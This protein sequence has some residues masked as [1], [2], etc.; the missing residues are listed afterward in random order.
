MYIQFI[1]TY[2][3]TLLS[4][5]IIYQDEALIAIH[6]PYGFFVHKSA[7]DA[8][9]DQ[10]VLNQLRDQIG[11]YVYP[12]HRLDRKTSGL[13]L[14]A[15]NKD[16]QRKMN[17]LFM[18]GE[19]SK[20]YHA[21]VRGHTPQSLTID[22]PLLHDD[23]RMQDAATVLE[24]LQKMEIPIANGNHPTSR[25]SLVKLMPK[26]GRM[27]QLRRHMAH[28]FHPILADRPHGCNKQNKLF[29]EKFQLHEMM[30]HARSLSFVKPGSDQ[31]L[32]IA[33]EYSNEFSRILNG[34]TFWVPNSDY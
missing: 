6:K 30:L 34:L 13:L 20:E 29:L 14:M 28:I 16:M 24:T 19:V 8:R 26:T 10:I 1:Q 11:Q 2:K 5:Q 17:D 9:A 32:T 33:C 7:L 3:F 27:H 25:Y 18:V 12:V 21:I 15:L 4:F 22:Y 31:K 23:G